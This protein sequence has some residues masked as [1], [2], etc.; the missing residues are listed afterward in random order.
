MKR[1]YGWI[2]QKQDPRDWKYKVQ[3]DVKLD[4]SADLRNQYMPFVWDQ[5]SEGSCTAHSVCGAFEYA[6][7]KGGCE[8]LM[9]S[10]NMVYYDERLMEGTPNSDEGAEIRDGIKTMASQG[11]CPETMWPY[12]YGNMLVRPT[13]DCYQAAMKYEAVSYQAVSQDLQD[14][15]QCLMNG[16]PVCFGFS[17]YSSFESQTVATTGVVPMP[18]SGEEVLGGHAVLAVGYNLATQLFMVRNSWGTGWGQAGYFTMPFQYL[19]DAN[20]ASDFWTIQ[21][22]SS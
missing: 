14:V 20:L 13:P 12:L 8:P 6:Q 11:A 7:A 4:P 3:R 9:V 18:G 10:R 1:N 2:Q 22:T 16:W 17:V 19:L 15:C 5:E 21:G